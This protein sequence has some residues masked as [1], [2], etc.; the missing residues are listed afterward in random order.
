MHCISYQ[1]AL[2]PTRLLCFCL[3]FVLKNVPNRMKHSVYRKMLRKKIFSE[4]FVRKSFINL[5]IFATI[6]RINAVASSGMPLVIDICW[7]I[8]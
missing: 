6:K 4:E 2:M 5:K 7:Y 1:R 8:V 3:L